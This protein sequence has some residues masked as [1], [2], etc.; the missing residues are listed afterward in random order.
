MTRRRIVFG[1]AAVV[2]LV[3]TAVTLAVLALAARVAEGVGSRV[4]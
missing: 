1:V 4:R 2:A 3:L